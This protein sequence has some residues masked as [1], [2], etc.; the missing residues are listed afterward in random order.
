MGGSSSPAPPPSTSVRQKVV[1][2][3]QP[4]W[5]KAVTARPVMKI[6]DDNDKDYAIWNP[7]P[8]IGDGG[9]GAPIPH[10]K[11]ACCPN[12]P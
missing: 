3:D 12:Q 2:E 5:P 8:Y 9:Y 7:A 6:E 4:P 1:A 10:A 11:D